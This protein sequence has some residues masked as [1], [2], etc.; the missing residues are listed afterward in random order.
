MHQFVRIGHHAMISGMAG[1]K[2]D[3]IPYGLLSAEDTKLSG[4]NLIGLKRRGFSSDEI[5]SIRRAYNELFDHKEKP[6]IE[7]LADVKKFYK[8]SKAVEQLLH[9]IE[10]QSDRSLCFPSD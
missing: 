8:D 5:Q 4:L 7:R 9:F 3:V 10:E 1:V 2:Y 6:F